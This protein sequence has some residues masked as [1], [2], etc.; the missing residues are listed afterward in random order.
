MARSSMNNLRK[1]TCWMSLGSFFDTCSAQ[2][3]AVSLHAKLRIMVNHNVMRYV[4]QG[5]MDDGY[6]TTGE[7]AIN[8][9]CSKRVPYGKLSRF[10]ITG[11]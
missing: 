11:A 2:I 1:A 7:R 9:R 3:L 8:M 4:T 6:E 5:V 10:V